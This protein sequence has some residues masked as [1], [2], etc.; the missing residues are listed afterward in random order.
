MIYRLEKKIVFNTCLKA[1]IFTDKTSSVAPQNTFKN[2]TH[3]LLIADYTRPGIFLKI[4][5]EHELSAHI[6]RWLFTSI[7]IRGRERT[8]FWHHLT[9]SNRLQQSRPESRS[10]CSLIGAQKESLKKLF[11]WCVWIG[12]ANC[13]SCSSPT[14]PKLAIPLRSV[15]HVGKVAWSWEKGDSPDWSCSTGNQRW[16][17]FRSR[18]IYHVQLAIKGKQSF[19]FNCTDSS[20]SL[21]F[22]KLTLTYLVEKMGFYDVFCRLFR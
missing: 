17:L 3:F 13:S 1:F 5:Q 7:R 18:K 9:S 22:I 12:V 21:R 10:N 11:L 2:Q 20:C 19:S 16:L 15:G 8:V 4:P 6:S 14:R